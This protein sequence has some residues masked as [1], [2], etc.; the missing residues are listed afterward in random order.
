MTPIRKPLPADFGPL[1]LVSAIWGSSFICNDIAL[2]H[3]RPLA[4]ACWRILLAGLVVLLITR[5]MQLKIPR[6]KYSLILLTGIGALNGLVPFTLIGWGQQTVNS[7]V[8]ALLITTSPFVTLLLSHYMT[9]DDRFSWNRLLGLLIGFLG[10]AVLFGQEILLS[11]NS[12]FGMLAIMLAAACYSMSAL[13]IRKLS[14]LPSLVIVSG[15]LLSMCVL[16][17]PL[18]L[19]FFPPWQ[20]ETSAKSLLALVFLALFPTAIAYVLR[21][22]IVR[23]NGAVFMSTAGYLIPLFAALWSWLFLD[24]VPAPIMWVAMALIFA[25]IYLG[26]RAGPKKTH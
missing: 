17:L 16:A 7:A 9:G 3:F 23:V 25:G 2:A 22:Q 20:Q 21:A 5:I 10:V 13:L 11:G 8:T 18:V 15:S 12:V 26:Q 4:I 1:F 6:D 19:W 24:E 14:H